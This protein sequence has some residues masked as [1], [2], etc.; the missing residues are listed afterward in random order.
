MAPVIVD[1][2]LAQVRRRVALREAQLPFADIK[3][4][5][6]AAPAP[7]DPFP[8]LLSPG[9]SV[10]TELP[11]CIPP[12]DSRWEMT[13]IADVA[14]ECEAH[15]AALL[16]CHTDM[17]AFCSTCEDMAAAKRAVDIPMIC[18][19]PIVDPYQLHEAKLYG[20]DVVSIPVGLLGQHHVESLVDRAQ[21]LGLTP[22]LEVR[23]TQSA[24]HALRLGAG[25]VGLNPQGWVCS[26]RDPGLVVRVAPM[27]HE[28]GVPFIMLSGVK[29]ESD[30]ILHARQHAHGVLVSAARCAQHTP[31]SLTRAMVTASQHPLAG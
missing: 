28:A 14:R 17:P 2:V 11:G 6:A 26:R 21:S 29:T 24:H 4:R 1:Y 3:V 8:A 12:G 19:D 9:C 13:S 23:D 5:A 30:L 16:S 15:G 20:A 27:L 25:M 31:G 7:R 22:L 10:I 18:R